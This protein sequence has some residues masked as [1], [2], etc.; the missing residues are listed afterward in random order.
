MTC[1]VTD[2]ERRE[3]REVAGV[4]APLGRYAHAVEYDG[5]VYVSGCGPFDETGNLVGGDDV[6]EQCRQTLANAERILAAAGTGPSRVI[7][8][9]VYLID[10]E[11]RFATRKVRDDFYGGSMPASTLIGVGCL[12][13]PRMRVEIDMIAAVD[14]R[15]GKQQ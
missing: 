3:L 1:G 15:K 11:D 4:H 8:E 13:D 9:H 5:L 7:R 12:V 14:R 10:I 2:A 6:A